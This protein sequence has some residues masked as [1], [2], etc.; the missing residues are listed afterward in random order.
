MLNEGDPA[1]EFRLP[2]QDGN[3]IALSSLRGK[4]VALYFYPAAFTKGCK[5]SNFTRGSTS[6]LLVAG[7]KL[8]T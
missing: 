8:T 4:K 2:A 3:E 5:P 7:A 6:K 1:P